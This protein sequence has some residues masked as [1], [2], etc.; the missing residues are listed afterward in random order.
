MLHACGVGGG[1][2][3][4]PLPVYCIAS[5]AVGLWACNL[6]RKSVGWEDCDPTSSRNANR[7][8]INTN[9]SRLLLGFFFGVRYSA[10]GAEPY[11]TL[12]SLAGLCLHAPQQR[13]VRSTAYVG[14]CTLTGIVLG[15]GRLLDSR[16][17]NP[18]RGHPFTSSLDLIAISEG[19]GELVISQLIPSSPDHLKDTLG[20]NQKLS[21]LLSPFY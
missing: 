5:L 19:E 9:R 15:N 7:V 18:P 17:P 12:W 1:V 4:L 21:F 6:W 2:R 16:K 14:R 11:I 10:P 13:C 20:S 8:S 3:H